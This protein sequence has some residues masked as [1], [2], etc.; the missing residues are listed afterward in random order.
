MLGYDYI[1]NNYK[2][3]SADLSRQKKKKK[4]KKKIDVDPKAIQ[5]VEFVRKLKNT[6]GVNADGTKSMFVLT[7]L[8]KITEAIQ[9]VSQGSVTVLWKMINYEEGR[10]KL[11]STQLNKLKPFGKGNIGTKLRIS[12]TIT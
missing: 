2:L 8:E 5:Q 7:I 4:K 10:V 9:K 12:K 1:K 3:T 11:T 6:D